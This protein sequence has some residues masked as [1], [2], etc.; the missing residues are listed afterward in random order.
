MVSL[1]KS[2]SFIQKGNFFYLIAIFNLFFLSAY[3]QKHDYTQNNF[4]GGIGFFRLGT[5]TMD[6]TSVNNSLKKKD[7]PGISNGFTSLGVG[8]Y[9]LINNAVFGIAGQGLIS[10]QHENADYNVQVTSGYGALYLGY[11]IYQKEKLQVYPM[12]GLGGA[13]L[14][15][16]IKSNGVPGNFDGFLKSPFL[17]GSVINGNVIMNFELNA[18]YFLTGFIKDDILK[19]WVGGLSVGYLVSP[20]KSGWQR[21]GFKIAESP[22]LRIESFYITLKLG[23]GKLKVQNKI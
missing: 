11:I 16:N 13:A 23:G 20:F 10:V 14:N 21:D 7:L 22:V 2:Y 1:I 6:L 9:R 12:F 5:A 19:G 4:S 8:G 15:L 18:D 17:E 3:C